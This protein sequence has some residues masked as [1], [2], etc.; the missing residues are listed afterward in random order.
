VILAIYTGLFKLLNPAI[1]CENL[2]DI[3]LDTTGFKC[4]Q[5]EMEPMHNVDHALH[6]M[7]W[8]CAFALLATG[9]PKDAAEASCPATASSCPAGCQEIRARGVVTTA[10]PPCVGESRV[11]GCYPDGA[12]VTD[13]DACVVT[14][15]GSRAFEVGG[16]DWV[17]LLS[18]GFRACTEEERA[19]WTLADGLVT[20]S[21]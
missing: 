18:H 17:R 8:L 3:F 9:C 7:G 1:S 4:Q 11:L 21:K 5:M 12:S 13:M 16:T 10:A 20:C 14:E 15:D 6:R 19:R 2:N